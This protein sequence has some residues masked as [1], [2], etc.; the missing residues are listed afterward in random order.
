MYIPLSGKVPQSLYSILEKR[1]D[2]S[3][4]GQLYCW[5]IPHFSPQTFLFIFPVSV[6]VQDYA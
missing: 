4:T 5:K 3:P 6:G 1:G 2:E